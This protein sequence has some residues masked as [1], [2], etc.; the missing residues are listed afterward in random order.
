[1]T[2]ASSRSKIVGVFLAASMSLQSSLVAYAASSDAHA[3]HAETPTIAYAVPDISHFSSLEEAVGIKSTDE[4]PSFG[5]ETPRFASDSGNP[6]GSDVDNS[7]DGHFINLTD[8]AAGDVPS[9]NPLL[10]R[11]DLLAS[12]TPTASTP[13][14]LNATI[15][16][17]PVVA[18]GRIDDLT[19]Q[20]LLKIVQL[21][22]FNLHYKQE[23]AKQGRWK[24]WRYGMLQEV[25]GGLNLAAGILATAERGS[26]L[27]QN[28]GHVPGGIHTLV[29]QDAMILGLVGS[30]IG[31]LA[32]LNELG[33]NEYHELQARH[34]G[35]GPGAARAHVEGLRSDID[36]L[37]AERT[38]NLSVERSANTLQG[39]AVVDDAE[40]KVL[41]DLRDQGLLE[42]ERFHVSARRLLAFQ[43][44]QYFF[45]F[46]KYTTNAIGYEFLFLALHKHHRY[47]NLRAGVQWEVSGA[48]FMLGPI[49]SRYIGKAVA[50]GHKKY[51]RSTVQE[52]ESAK[53]DDLVRDKATLDNL[54]HA[55]QA[56]EDAASAVARA[57]IY[58]DQSK[59]F[60]D[61]LQVGSKER[62]KAKLTATQNI[63]AGLYVGASKLASGVMA[64]VVGGNVHYR[65]TTDRAARVTNAGLFVSGVIGLPATTFAM[66][67]T[68]RIQ[69]EG[70]LNRKKLMNAGTHPTQLIHARLAQLDDIERRLGVTPAVT[71]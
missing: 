29:Q 34:H 6:I 2:T 47:W 28:G 43:Q 10:E 15:T 18:K 37:M 49:V 16:N 55:T 33:I 61:E 59:V 40:G 42:F 54:C 44:S 67:D 71:K 26:H 66:V 35:Y 56:P 22:R 70:E 14:V 46:A 52:A 11:A 31:A 45:D 25:N 13:V 48:I 1:M 32:A 65:S 27:R 39:H 41:T 51:V 38:A 7:G 19:R 36:R 53:V 69:V 58:G 50:E 5:V 3:S 12:A 8:L 57:N 68:L 20:I 23:V 17:D 30:S 60:Q 24:G 21:E 62:N 63:G 4:A 64:N 9:A